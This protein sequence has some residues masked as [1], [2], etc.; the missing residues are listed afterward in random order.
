MKLLDSINDNVIFIPARSGST[1]LKNKNLQ[2][3]N[4]KSL[5]TIKILSCKKCIYYWN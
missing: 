4:G 1:R 5:L 3:I 2:K